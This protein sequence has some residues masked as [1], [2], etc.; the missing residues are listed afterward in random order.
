MAPSPSVLR[1][2]LIP[3]A[4]ARLAIDL[5][6][7]AVVAIAAVTKINKVGNVVVTASDNA[8]LAT[9]LNRPSNDH[10]TYLRLD[11]GHTHEKAGRYPKT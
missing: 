10:A 7:K 6:A 5:Q 8:T 3:I 9:M 4:N 1:K 2:A 11:R